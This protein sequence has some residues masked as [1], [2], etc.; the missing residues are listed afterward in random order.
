[1][2]E[3]RAREREIVKVSVIGIIANVLLAAFKA[4]VGM[5]AH[6][7][8]IVMD[9]L[10][11]MSDAASSLI[12]IIGAKLAGREA[13]KKHPFGYGRVEYLSALVIS[14]I[15]L[16]AGIT[17]FVESIKKILHPETPD[18]SSVA[19]IIVAVAVLVKV[20]LG[21]FT[22]KRGANLRSDSL[23]NSGEDATH[24][25][26]ISATTLVAAAIYLIFH[27]S[28]EAWLGA[29]ISVVIVKAGVDMIKDSIS[30][31][32]GE[33]ADIDLARE[34]KKSVLAFDNVQGVYDLVLHNYGPDTYQGSLHIEVLD[35][36]PVDELDELLRTITLKIYKEHNILLTAIGVYTINTKNQTANAMREKVSEYVHRE[37]SV[38]QM[39]AFYVNEKKKTLRFDLVISL[40]EKDRYGLY[41]K[42][43]EGVQALYPEYTLQ[44]AMDTD[45]TEE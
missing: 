41:Q 19:L 32:L 44:I 27:V 31:I 34:L 6:S 18:Y 38:L 20:I 35:T 11:N 5:S 2:E 22:K 26:V 3:K 45:F 28:L 1:M 10:N 23:V 14:V 25:A 43:V 42:L 29:A 8:A 33:R 30:T 7:I 24:D 17:S 12:T 21:L 16:Y 4:A 37:K 40:G 13:D 36:F 15:V 9:A 39:H